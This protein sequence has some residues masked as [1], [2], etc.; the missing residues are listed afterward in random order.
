[1]S[2]LRHK[3][4]NQ[5]VIGQEN[6]YLFFINQHNSCLFSIGQ[7][8]I[9][10]FPVGDTT[11]S[12]SFFHKSSSINLLSIKLISLKCFSPHTLKPIPLSP[13]LPSSC[14]YLSDVRRD[15]LDELDDG[16]DGQSGMGLRVCEEKHLSDMGL[17]ESKFTK[18]LL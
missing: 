17:M 9:C 18:L 13:S 8:N 7:D 1:M 5:F 10:L 15:C 3:K 2:F 14:S 6:T 11:S 16:S 4:I 12:T